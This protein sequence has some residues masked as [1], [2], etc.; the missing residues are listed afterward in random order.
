MSSTLAA[1]G[2]IPYYGVAEERGWP[3][4]WEEAY[5]AARRMEAEQRQSAAEAEVER[6]RKDLE[7]AALRK[8]R[9]LFR[10]AT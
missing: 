2:A 7:E 9:G 6:L 5:A 10:R 3:A 8:R 4:L 1:H